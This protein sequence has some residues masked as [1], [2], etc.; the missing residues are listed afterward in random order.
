[1]KVSWRQ[2]R[3]HLV[4]AFQPEPGDVLEYGSFRMFRHR[5]A[6]DMPPGWDADRTHPDLLAVAAFLAVRPFVGERLLFPVGISAPLAEVMR[7]AAGPIDPALAPRPLP[8]GGTP[9][10][11]YSGGVDS[12]AALALLPPAAE[13]VHLLRVVPPALVWAG[14]AGRV[15]SPRRPRFQSRFRS[16]A[17]LHAVEA[18]SRLGRAAHVVPTDLEFLR[19]PFGFPVDIANAVPALLMAD[20]RHYDSIAFGTI[21]ESAYSI[22]R[23][24][25]ADYARRDHFR[26]YGALLDAVGMPLHQ[27]TAG[28]SEVGTVRLVS[29]SAYGAIAQSCNRGRPGE[30]CLNCYKCF[31]KTLLAAAVAG[32]G[33]DVPLADRLLAIPEAQ[34]QMRKPWMKHEN[35]LAY[36]TRHYRGDHQLLRLLRRRVRGD[37]LRVR[38][39]ERWYPPAAELL[40]AH[41]RAEAVASI[42]GGFQAM[43][44]SQQAVAESW[45]LASALK[46]PEYRRR[47]ARLIAALE[48]R[49]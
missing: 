14:R 39:M 22:G 38:W 11:A 3:H 8:P 41:R 37:S 23:T 27:L 4:F 1:V 9:A 17:G 31:R 44:P 42:L 10:L 18:V 43:N 21:M 16:E 35:V 7:V 47:R 12:T 33:I 34:A 2:R 32:T 25:F 19:R 20:L 45:D 6:L 36:A 26:Q 30:P 49:G 15:L 28:L 40:P 5:C 13:P 46:T 48:N 29:A 24:R